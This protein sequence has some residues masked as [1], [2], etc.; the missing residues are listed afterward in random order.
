MSR[1]SFENLLQKFEDY[2][3]IYDDAQKN[4]ST[5]QTINSSGSEINMRSKLAIPLRWLA[6]ASYLDLCFAWGL[7]IGS[8][9][10]DGCVL[11]G[12]LEAIDDLFDIGMP[13]ENQNE[14]KNIASGFARYSF[15]RL[16][17]CV[18]AIDG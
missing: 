15:G 16:K 5:Q 9:Y 10:A 8:F 2:F 6:G 4:K 11:W 13:F 3:D 14:L 18:L 17:N 7:A 1:E 12:T